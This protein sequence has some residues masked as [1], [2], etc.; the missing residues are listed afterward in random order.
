MT[1]FLLWNVDRRPLDGLVQNL[2]RQHQIDI[3]LLVEYAFGVSQL[4]GFLLPDGLFKCLSPDRFGVFV[5]DTYRLRRLRY[6]LGKRAGLWALTPPSGQEGLMVLLHGFDRR[7]CDDS[8]RRMF[9]RR[10]AD[11]V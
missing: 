7:N 3:V 5:R 9:L 6:R 1:A 10:I 2:V 4:S 11:T 8:T